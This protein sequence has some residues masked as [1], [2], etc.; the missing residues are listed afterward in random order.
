MPP[1]P[2]HRHARPD[3]ERKDELW[4]LRINYIAHFRKDSNSAFMWKV[5][6]KRHSLTCFLMAKSRSSQGPHHLNFTEASPV[7]H[8]Q[9]RLMYAQGSSQL[10]KL[11][12]LFTKLVPTESLYSS[13][14]TFWP[15][16]D[17]MVKLT[18]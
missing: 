18:I 13:F 14:P 8:I 5:R 3:N 7:L 1:L 16:Q 6:T 9:S 10:F 2:A 15:F 4:S 11:D 12:R 17:T